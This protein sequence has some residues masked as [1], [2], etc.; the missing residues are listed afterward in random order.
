LQAAIILPTIR[1]LPA[2]LAGGTAKM[3]ADAPLTIAPLMLIE[4]YATF[5]AAEVLASSVYHNNLCQQG[6]FCCT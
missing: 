5:I 3:S 1:Q 4:N 6:A 2:Y